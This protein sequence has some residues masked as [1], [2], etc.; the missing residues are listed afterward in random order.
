MKKILYIHHDGGIGGAPKSLSFLIN[1]LDKTNY[2]PVV[3][4][5]MDGPA[6]KLF[7]DAGAKVIVDTRLGA[8]HGSTVSGMSFKLFLRNILYLLPSYFLAKLII[9]RINPDIIHLNSASLFIYAKAANKVDKSIPIVSHIR[10]PLLNSFFGDILKFM[11]HKYVDYYIAIEKYDLSTMNTK[12]KLTSVVY[13]S[14]DFEFYNPD[15]YSNVIKDELNLRNDDILILYLARITKSNGA[16]ELVRSIKESIEGT[17][18]HLAVIGY[19]KKNFSKY[20]EEVLKE[21]SSNIHIM[22][23]RDDVPN[24]IASSDIMVVPFTQP[25]F[26]RSVIE[27]AAMGKPSVVSNVKGLDELVV[28]GQTGI[29][30]DLKS[31]QDLL[32][33]IKILVDD[34]PLRKSMGEKA[35]IRAKEL[36]DTKKNSNRIFRIYDSLLK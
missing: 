35:Y 23:L 17:N 18:I 25:H 32:N 6:R 2:E 36:F 27:A 11:N 13:N 12:N 8:F 28:D 10:E 26:A 21:S 19:D 16:L 20:V 30:Y 33:S 15:V 3:L 1:D 9:K 7:E 4:M 24:V 5:V 29:I 34:E 22:E 14:V 31:S